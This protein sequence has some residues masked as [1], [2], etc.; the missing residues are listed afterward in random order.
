METACDIRPETAMTPELAQRVKAHK[1]ALL[2]I[3]TAGDIPA[4]VQWQA[5]LDLVEGDPECSLRRRWRPAGGLRFR[6]ES[7]RP[8]GA[9]TNP[10]IKENP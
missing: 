5:A 9:A 10:A 6:W 7:E 1:P 8:D 3:L 4:A 2:A